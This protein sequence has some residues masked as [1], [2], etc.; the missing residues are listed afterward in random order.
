MQ[1]KQRSSFWFLLPIVFNVIGGIIAFFVIRE[2]DPKKARNCLYLGIILAAIPI[3]LI[4]VPI[5]IG[6]TL[7]PHIGP[8][9]ASNTHY[10]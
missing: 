2:D 6:I 10:V 5:L 1:V 7:F 8:S 9:V 4:V 3:L